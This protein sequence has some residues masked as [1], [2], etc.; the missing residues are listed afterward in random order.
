MLFHLSW[1]PCSETSHL[2]VKCRLFIFVVGK[3]RRERE[4]EIL[5]ISL[6]FSSKELICSCNVRNISSFVS[7][8][9]F[10]ALQQPQMGQNLVHLCSVTLWDISFTKYNAYIKPHAGATPDL[11]NSKAYTTRME[12]QAAG[13][14]DLRSM[15]TYHLHRAQWV[16]NTDIDCWSCTRYWQEMEPPPTSH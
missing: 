10:P 9:K 15:W 16:H 14:Q 4:R 5:D 6:S 3:E 7:K 2:I 8:V 12:R 13:A 1:E 11:K